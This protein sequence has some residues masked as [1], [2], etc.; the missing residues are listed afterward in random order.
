MGRGLDRRTLLAGAAG[1]AAATALGGCRSSA[2]ASRGKAVVV[3]AGLAG[4]TAAYELERAG[5][6]VT[7][8]EARDRLG[9]RVY[10]I[11]G[12][13]S[14]QHAEAG[15]EY[16]DS[17]HRQIQLY[18]RRFGIPLEDVRRGRSDL[19]TAIF[20]DGERERGW[21]FSNGRVRRDR[22]DFWRR[23]YDLVRRVRLNDP[24]A[25]GGAELDRH[26]V[27]DFIDRVGIGGR[28]RFLL[29]TLIRGDYAAEPSELSLLGVCLAE[30]GSWNQPDAGV[31]IYRLRGGNS[32]LVEAFASRLAGPVLTSAPVSA[33][34]QGASGIRVTV[35]DGRALDAD[36]CVLAAPLPALRSVSFDPALP[37]ALGRAVKELD[38][39][40]VAKMLV[41]YRRRFWRLRGFSGDVATDLAIGNAWE[42][43]DRQRG[44]DGVL[45]AY[46]AGARGAQAAGVNERA[47]IRRAV[48]N[49]DR[50]FPGSRALAGRAHS[51]AWAAEPYSGGAWC[52][53]RPGQVLPFWNALREPVGRIQLAGEHTADLGGY[54][55]G[56]IRSGQRAAGRIDSA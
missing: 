39:G 7:V 45:I 13:D 49:L 56:A 50:T 35:A 2:A 25:G 5:W 22:T 30:R 51:V 8:L 31:E 24:S 11:Y 33:I 19:D 34:E 42:A 46:A 40:P 29:E 6:E 53:Y 17:R 37:E 14:G 52:V 41:Q 28:A 23:L 26:S 15:G 54:M 55:E 47:R 9:G 36:H 4:L 18:A 27:A 3:G 44:R 32:R 48:A 21:R 16:V 43:T 12:F 10:T 20:I 38:N 1:L